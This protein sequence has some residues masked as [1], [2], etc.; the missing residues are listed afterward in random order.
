M[1]SKKRATEVAR[2]YTMLEAENELRRN[3]CDALGVEYMNNYKQFLSFFDGLL[4]FQ[5]FDDQGKRRDLAQILH[6]SA[7]S[8]ARD[9]MK[10]NN[11]G[12]GVFLTVNETDGQGRKR[13][14]IKRVRAVFVDLDGSPLEPVQKF[15]LKPHIIVESSAGR[16]HAYWFAV[17][18]P[19][20]SFSPLQKGL[21]S[22]FNGDPVVHD[23]SRVMRVPGFYHK[24]NGKQPVQ[25]L[26]YSYHDYYTYKELCDHI[27]L[28]KVK[29]WSIRTPITPGH[30]PDGGWHYG[31]SEGMR[32]NKLFR[33][34]IAMRKRGESFDLALSEAARWAAACIP[35][36]EERETR[37][38]VE[39]VW[40]SYS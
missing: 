29:Q 10:L 38:L 21:A 32:N 24:K 16:Y 6:G 1:M 15:E 33:V 20:K 9:L 35:P 11:A 25:L 5:T 37:I 26:E 4:T 14:N 39:H 31:S 23:L 18:V 8:C 22:M 17:D 40:R 19:P 7:Q 27:K 2:K 34:L 36:L 13:D 28:P 12:A 3:T 30:V